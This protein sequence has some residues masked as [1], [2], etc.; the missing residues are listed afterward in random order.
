MSYVEEGV[1]HGKRKNDKTWCATVMGVFFFILL[2]LMRYY[3]KG[4]NH[5][6]RTDDKT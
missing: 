1:N 6:K 5:G 3:E 2:G 4:V